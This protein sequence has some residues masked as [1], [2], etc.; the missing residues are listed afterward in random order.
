MDVGVGS[1]V[2]S[3]GIIS[4]RPFLRVPSAIN[5]SLNPK[6]STMLVKSIK[7]SVP[8]LLLGLVRVAMV[9]A[10]DYPVSVVSNVRPLRHTRSRL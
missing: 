7:K 9:K 5:P 4:A 3:L 8:T 6:T 10:A 2:L 1:F